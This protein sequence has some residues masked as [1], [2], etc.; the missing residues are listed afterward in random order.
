MSSSIRHSPKLDLPSS[1]SVAHGFPLCERH[2]LAAD[3]FPGHH[4]RG[5][6]A[7]RSSV[8]RVVE[9]YLLAVKHDDKVG[10]S[11]APGYYWAS[12]GRLE[13]IEE[14]HSN[15]LNRTRAVR[16]AIDQEDSCL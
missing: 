4:G 2:E 6:P 9:L 14:A 11:L 1:A 5:Q 13:Q 8:G 10:V 16:Q 3:A 12:L 15:A 7:R